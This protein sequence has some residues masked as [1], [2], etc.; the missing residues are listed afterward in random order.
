ML[1][2]GKSYVDPSNVDNS[3]FDSNVTTFLSSVDSVVCSADSLSVP[4]VSVPHAP[5]S[6]AELSA[7]TNP[8]LNNA[9]IFP[10]F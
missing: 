8:F 7:T 3:V 10:S 2:V 6:N 9:I 1:V 4:P 5:S